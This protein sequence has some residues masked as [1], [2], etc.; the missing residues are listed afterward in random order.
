VFR[1][2]EYQVELRIR[3]LS[4]PK[5]SVELAVGKPTQYAVSRWLLRLVLWW[6]W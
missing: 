4:R 2:I 5:S 6:F 1:S 3:L